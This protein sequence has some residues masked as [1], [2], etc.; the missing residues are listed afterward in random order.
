MEI[1]IRVNIFNRF[2]PIRRD[3]SPARSPNY[4]ASGNNSPHPGNR[5]P[6]KNPPQVDEEALN[7]TA[8]K[9]KSLTSRMQAVVE[10]SDSKSGEVTESAASQ[11]TDINKVSSWASIVGVNSDISKT[12]SDLYGAINWDGVAKNTSAKNSNSLAANLSP[13]LES[14]SANSS[15]HKSSSTPLIQSDSQSKDATSSSIEEAVK[16]FLEKTQASV[17]H[18]LIFLAS[19]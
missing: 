3:F 14:N 8:E 1:L 16:N 17:S 12:L 5:T 15:L 11:S 7:E 10:V 13:N 2:L 9:P 4:S 18:L 19:V 6:R